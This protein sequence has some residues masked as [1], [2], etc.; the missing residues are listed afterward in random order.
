MSSAASLVRSRFTSVD[1]NANTVEL[2]S[3][4][5]IGSPNTSA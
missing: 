3:S 2:S 5:T 4:N 1:P